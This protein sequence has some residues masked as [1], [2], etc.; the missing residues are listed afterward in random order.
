MIELTEKEKT[1]LMANFPF[2]IVKPR[3]V[4]VKSDIS[5]TIP[6]KEFPLSKRGI[7]IFHFANT[8]RPDYLLLE[9]V[10]NAT[11]FYTGRCYSNT[12]R[13]IENCK[14]AGVEAVKPYAGWL[15]GQDGMVLHH[16]WAT[17]EA[18][19]NTCLIDGSMS[20]RLFDYIIEAGGNRQIVLEK[21]KQDEALPNTEKKVFGWAVP[22]LLYVGA[23][24]EPTDAL[25]MWEDLC[26]KYPNHVA[27]NQPGQNQYGRSRFQEQMAEAGLN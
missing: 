9:Q 15:I 11:E 4:R 19:G 18:D 16:A 27:Y 3:E 26:R 23:Q 1:F 7:K 20:S 12:L 13:F 10:F 21:L 2:A 14:E 8:G 6:S 25:N 24:T 22:N 5:A 17:Y